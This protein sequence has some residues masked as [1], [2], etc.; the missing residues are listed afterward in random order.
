MKTILEWL[1]E[2]KEQGYEWADAAI[3]NYDPK[4]ADFGENKQLDT[5]SDA[6][7]G[8]FDWQDN[9]E[10]EDFWVKIHMD[11]VNEETSEPTPVK[12]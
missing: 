7:D 3:R 9:P 10:G 2:A 8:A 11:L 12:Q 4:F 6:L 5:L 1:N